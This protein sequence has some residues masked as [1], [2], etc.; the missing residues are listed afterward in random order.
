MQ[1]HAPFEI[2]PR[3][4]LK[5]T[6]FDNACAVD[7]NV[8]PAKAIDDLMNSGFNLCGIEQVALNGQ[9]RAAARSEISLSAR[10]FIRV[11]R[12]EGNAPAL[13][14]NLSCKHEPESAR[15]ACDEDYFVAQ[16]ITHSANG[17]S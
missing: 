5:R 8:N 9:D 12:N 17:A 4:V 16:R 13:R 6:N 11:A 1:P 10:Q 14:A 7:Q 15:T 3:H 2:L